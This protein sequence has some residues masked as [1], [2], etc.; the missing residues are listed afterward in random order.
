[1]AHN[2]FRGQGVYAIARC[3]TWPRDKCQINASSMVAEGAGCSPRDQV[4][5]G[6]TDRRAYSLMAKG[7]L[8]EELWDLGGSERRDDREGG[9]VLHAWR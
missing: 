2:A 9:C 4:L 3:C 7:V 6:N 1:M 5:T 8:P